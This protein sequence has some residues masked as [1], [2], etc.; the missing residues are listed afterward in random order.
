MTLE[1]EPIIGPDG[2]TIDLNLSPEVVEFDGFINYGS[3]INGPIF[4]LADPADRHGHP[5]AERHQSADF[6]HAQGYHE[7]KHL[8]WSNRRAWRIWCVRTFKR[9]RDK[10]PILGDIPLA[11]RLFRSNVDQKIKRNLIIFVTARLMDAEGRPVRLDEDVG[12]NCRAFGP[13]QELPPPAYESPS[14]GK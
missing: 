11:G 9:F 2:Y 13:P 6:F 4:N 5:H 3:P 14:F 1:V 10:V 7:C 8:G 12:G